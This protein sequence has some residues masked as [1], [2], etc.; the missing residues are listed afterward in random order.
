MDG[1]LTADAKTKQLSGGRGEE[2]RLTHT[3]GAHLVLSQQHG[4]GG[5]AYEGWGGGSLQGCTAGKHEM[6]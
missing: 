3:S 2:G 5:A 6:E 4:T 1:L